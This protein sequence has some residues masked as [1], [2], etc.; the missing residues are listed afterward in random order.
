[1]SG[2]DDP[3]TGLVL[4]G[5]GAHAAYQAGVLAALAQ[6]RRAAGVERSRNPFAI[7]AGSS[8][9]AI[10]AA[11]LACRC[12]DFERAADDLAS[13]W[14]NL[15]VGHIY[16]GDVLRVT[17]SGA[18]WLAMLSVGWALA[19][20]WR[21]RPHALL[22]NRPLGELLQRTIA[23]QRLP[24][25][26]A[27]R[28]LRALAV[29]ASSY[30]SGEHVT[31]F[32]SGARLPAWTRAHR[33]AVETELTHAHLLAS[34]AIPF[35]FPSTRLERNGRAEWFGDGSMR[36]MAPLSPAI[37]LG[38][39]RLLVIAAG[40][41]PEP[42]GRTQGNA[43]GHPSLAQIAGH[44]LSSIFVDALAYDVERLQRLN[45][46]AALMSDEARRAAPL[47]TVQALVI[48]PSR[49]P[50]E[51]AL[52]HLEALPLAVRAVLG[53]VGVRAAGAAPAASGAALASYVLF[54]SS[55]TR[56]LLALGEADTLARAGEV[57]R[58][59]GWPERDKT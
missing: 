18:R 17:R 3:I 7:I 14:R 25:L 4:G 38:A 33:V 56:A 19:R 15:R 47:R 21:L 12:D 41:M 53:A 52:E 34:S 29:T 28:Q 45:R 57:R 43:S 59:F 27:A 31:F 37:H 55:Y 8:A 6:L 2:H 46:V 24:G 54:E 13:V 26:I 32:Q 35:V 22:D 20:R 10:N 42:A 39:Q 51:V 48:A 44:A 11:A 5:G 16:H 36:Q 30:D 49:R 40:G 9:G 23:L 50:D 1:M 58:F